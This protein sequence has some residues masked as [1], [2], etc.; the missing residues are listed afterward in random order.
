MMIYIATVEVRHSDV[1]QGVV[2]IK[3]NSVES[4]IAMIGH[5]KTELSMADML[6]E[7]VAM[8]A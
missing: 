5:G 8:I 2:Q 6:N 4:A 7:T 1:N 3:E